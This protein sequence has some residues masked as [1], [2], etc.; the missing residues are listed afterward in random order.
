[1]IE[2][3]IIGKNSIPFS[4]G[5]NPV[6]YTNLQIRRPQNIEEDRA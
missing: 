1:M 2:D 4:Q 6:V 3:R 5:I